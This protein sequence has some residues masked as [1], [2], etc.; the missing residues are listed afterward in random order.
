MTA[1]KRRV[2]IIED[3][4][5]IAEVL[6]HNLEREDYDVVHSADGSEGLRL[7]LESPPDLLILDLMLPGL[8]GVSICKR[9]RQQPQTQNNPILMLT[10][11]DEETDQ[12]KGFS[13]GADDYV[14]KPFSVKVLLERVRVLLARPK[15]P[16]SQRKLEGMGIVLDRDAHEATFDGAVLPLTPTEFRL[17][18]AL[19]AQPGKAFARADLLR[20]VVGDD[21]IV[22]ERTIDVHIRSLRAKLGPAAEAIE[23]VRGVGYRFARGSKAES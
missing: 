9:L 8:D 18:E 20:E 21:T 2:M 23:T 1:A 12:V 4:D 11:K 10:A 6:V 13:V 19:L 16:S 14:T 3:D 15:G 22:L 17:L 7:A 5:A